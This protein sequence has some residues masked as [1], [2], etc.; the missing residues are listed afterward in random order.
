VDV[1][2]HIVLRSSNILLN[3]ADSEKVHTSKHL[4]ITDFHTSNHISY[5]AGTIFELILSFGLAK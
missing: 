3:D 4:Y 1:F 2:V 5:L